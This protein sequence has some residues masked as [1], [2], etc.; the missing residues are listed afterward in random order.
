MT[1]SCCIAHSPGDTDAVFN[2]VGR[3]SIWNFPLTCVII[4]DSEAW[5]ACL[6]SCDWC[7]TRT[8]EVCVTSEIIHVWFK[9]CQSTHVYV[10]CVGDDQWR[11]WTR[12]F[13][14]I[15][16]IVVELSLN[17]SLAVFKQFFT[18]KS[19]IVS[20]IVGFFKLKR[21]SDY[22]GVWLSRFHRMPVLVYVATA[23]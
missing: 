3:W 23:R 14:D 4:L 6:M 22:Q 12:K 13:E 20:P 15:L 9:C 2:F 21:M 1:Y 7:H 11:S 5:F 16:L 19:H 18:K 8:C 10:C 17:F